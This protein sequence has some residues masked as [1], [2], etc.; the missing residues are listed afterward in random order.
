M[1]KWMKPDLCVN[2]LTDAMIVTNYAYKELCIMNNVFYIVSR[3]TTPGF[4]GRYYAFVCFCMFL[5]VS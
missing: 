2:L 3:F 4:T 5:D 1:K